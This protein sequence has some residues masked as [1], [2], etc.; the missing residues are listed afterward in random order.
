MCLRPP[1]RWQP[2]I[3]V[4]NA[5][6]YRTIAPDLP[7]L[8]QSDKPVDL[9]SYN[10]QST[11]TPAILA[12]IETLRLEKFSVVGHD[13]GAGLAWTLAFMIPDKVQHVV[14]LSVGYLG[15]LCDC[16]G[17]VRMCTISWLDAPAQG[18]CSAHC[19]EQ[20]FKAVPCTIC[21]HSHSPTAVVQVHL[22]CAAP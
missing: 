10:F 20:Q 21:I 12:L 15:E 8:G 13:F 18:P 1:C 4:L 7:G 22:H 6:G 14:V 19:L 3:A 9:A 5:A 2:Q 17:P 11:M 16:T